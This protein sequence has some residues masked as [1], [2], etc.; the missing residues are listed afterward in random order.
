MSSSMST[1]CCTYLREPRY[2]GPTGTA[3]TA[4]LGAAFFKN[5]RYHSSS[6]RLVGAV[7]PESIHTHTHANAR[8]FLSTLPSVYPAS[9]L[10]FFFCLPPTIALQHKIA[11]GSSRWT[12]RVNRLADASSAA[13]PGEHFFFCTQAGE[14]DI[15]KSLVRV[16]RRGLAGSRA[17]LT[18]NARVCVCVYFKLIFHGARSLGHYITL[19]VSSF[20]GRPRGCV[21]VMFVL[22]RIK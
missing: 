13:E 14:L 4:V 18:F 20:C 2:V 15:G 16:R 12:H 10:C 3:C 5:A 17:N 11:T 1:W 8:L 19:V 7:L 9:F 21:Q 6:S 22:P